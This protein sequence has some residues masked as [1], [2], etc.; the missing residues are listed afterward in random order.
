MQAGAK[1]VAEGAR[2]DALIIWYMLCGTV[3]RP[4]P[5][6]VDPARATLLPS[7]LKVPPP[8]IYLFP[9]TKPDAR[10]NPN[11]PAWR[12]EEL[13]FIHALATTFRCKA[14][15]IVQVRIQTQ[16]N[17]ANIER[18]TTLTRS[19]VIL[20]ESKWTQIKRASS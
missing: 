7:G 5:K 12:L 18:K 8:C 4:C 19:G 11:P 9:R 6:L 20:R 14:E 15:E 2:V 1:I 17:G 16:M 3:A 10:N 13:P